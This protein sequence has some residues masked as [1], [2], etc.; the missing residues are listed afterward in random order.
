MWYTTREL[1]P[2]YSLRTMINRTLSHPTW[3]ELNARALA[4]NIERFK[5]I[6]PPRAHVAVVV[7]ANAY[8]HG[9]EQIGSLLDSNDHVSYLL[10]A[11]LDEAIRLRKQG[12]SKSI[13]IVNPV[14]T[15]TDIAA[16]YQ[17]DLMV[18]DTDI[19]DAMNNAARQVNKQL[20]IHLKVDTGLSRF[21]YHPDQIPELITLITNEYP[22]LIIKGLYTHFAES[23]NS[24]L[25]YTQWQQD[26]FSALIDR[27]VQA[28]ITI[29]LIHYANTAATT[30]LKHHPAIN[31]FR[32]GAGA[33]GIWPSESTRSDNWLPEDCP[34]LK[35]VACWKTRIVHIKQVPAGTFVGYNRT[36]RTNRE[37]TI[38]IIPVGYYDGF[39]KRL[40]NKGGVHIN[41]Q[42]A[43]II[44]TIGMNATMIDISHIPSVH[45][46]SEVT[47]M[48]RHPMVTPYDLAHQTGCFNP[49]QIFTQINPLIPRVVVAQE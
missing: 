12:V 41:G 2:I 20:N 23:N 11:T 27:L 44:G 29:P 47:L 1:Q 26:Q 3:L 28:G 46:D 5:A 16:D 8:G 14:R 19:L 36:Y 18:T 17:V 32:I 24:D 45:L 4:H 10:V 22:H 25:S 37:A 9:L 35:L 43:P 39:D 48:G 30:S 38:G 42:T 21:G 31:F 34:N 6:I 33:Y 40:S 13:L 7:K 49:R 15:D